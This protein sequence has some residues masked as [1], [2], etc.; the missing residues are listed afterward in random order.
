MLKWLMRNRINA[1]ERKLGYDM[2]Y[3]REMLETDP[4][5]GAP[6]TAG[7]LA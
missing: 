7:A 4:K 2:S 1:F 3:I 5:E 6:A